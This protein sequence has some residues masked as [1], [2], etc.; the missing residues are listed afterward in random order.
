MAV[1]D[2]TDNVHHL[3]EPDAALIR[4][5][6]ERLFRRCPAEYPGGLIEIAWSDRAGQI[7]NALT[8]PSD[9]AGIDFAIECAIE[10]NRS[11]ANV[12][13]GAN[14]RKP[15]TTRWRAHADDIEISFFHFVECDKAESLA[16]LR[17]AP[18]PYCF[19]V[20]TGRRPHDRVHG[21]WELSVPTHDLAAWA[22]TQ[23]ALQEHFK[24]DAMIDP[25]RVLR[26]AGTV[27]YPPPHKITRGYKI[28][29]VTIRT[30][31]ADENGGEPHERRPVTGEVLLNAYRDTRVSEG[32]TTSG[33]NTVSQAA[34]P[35]GAGPEPEQPGRSEESSDKPNFG[36]V[37]FDIAGRIDA[38]R[39]GEEWHNNV[40]ALIAHLVTSGYAEA[41]ILAM[42]AELTL[43]GWTVDQTRADLRTMIEGAR[44]KWPPGGNS[45]TDTEDYDAAPPRLS[46][47]EVRWAGRDYGPIP[48]REWLLG[49]V[50]CRMFLSMLTGSGG[51]GK[52]A[53]R[54]L[55]YIAAALGCGVL[56]GEHVFRRARILIVCLEDDENEVRRRIRAACLHHKRIREED[57]EGWLFY[58]T[59]K[60]IRLLEADPRGNLRVGHLGDEL[61]RIVSEHNIDLIG[62]DPF[63]KAHGVSEND[64]DA[65]DRAATLLVEIGVTCRCA[66]DLV[67]H[68]RKGTATAGDADSGRGASSLKDA[69]RLVSMLTPMSEND[70]KLFDVGEAERKMLVRLDDAKVN[71]APPAARARW[72]KLVG[73]DLGNGTEDYPNGDEVQTVEVWTP[74]DVFQAL[75]TRVI[76]L[77]LDRIDEGLPGEPPGRRYSPTARDTDRA[78]WSVVQEHYPGLTK[79]QCQHVIKTW[80]NNDVLKAEPYHDPE[81]RKERQGL[82]VGKRPGD[83]WEL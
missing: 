9:A 31:Y 60:N 3:F 53:V 19:A 1:T 40:L 75:T 61:R 54:L 56:V 36:E 39:R 47:P 27:S 57:L 45:D 37:G 66:V 81:Q 46:Q 7:T 51:V 8:F 33:D 65:I 70:A 64:N 67:H 24:G 69:G 32:S 77:I 82:V 6:L 13:V 25:P 22:A 71:L 76:N 49:T 44:Q 28:E 4:E 16:P 26:L 42:A 14:P 59:P 10:R 50:F 5:H 62:I 72:F 58:W 63:I 43:A 18:L 30:R 15:G 23:R 2:D 78:A 17:S 38:I 12:Y 79:E 41:V 73:V 74:P 80:V 35:L 34:E 21:Y 55:Q 29:P 83:T 20:V 68:H 52:T 48:P 11:A